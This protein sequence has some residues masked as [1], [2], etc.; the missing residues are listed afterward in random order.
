MIFLQTKF[1][2]PRFTSQRIA[3]PQLAARIREHL[4][5]RVVMLIAPPGYGKTT[6]MADAVETPACPV[7]WYQLDETDNDPT[8][9]MAYLLHGICQTLP[10]QRAII[11]PLIADAGVHPPQRNLV[12][13]LNTLTEHVSTEWTLVLDDYHLVSH[14][15][16][17]QL[18]TLLIDNA[19]PT[20]GV[21]LAARSDPP[22]PLSRWRVRGQLHELRAEHL[23]FSLDEASVWLAR[24][25]PTLK[26][27]DIEHLVATTEGWGAGL[28]LAANLLSSPTAA[29][30]LTEKLDG[31][32]Q[33]IFNYLMEEVFAHQ[34]VALQHFLLDSA[35]FPQ[36]SADLCRQVLHLDNAE[37]LLTLVQRANLFLFSLDHQRHWYRYHP[38]FREF[39]LDRLARQSAA[40]LTELQHHAAQYYESRAE[41][42]SALQYYLL[43]GDQARAAEMLKR[44][45][46]DYL[47]H[48]RV[49]V[50]CRYFAQLTYR[51]SP[52]MLLLHG[53][54]LRQLG[55]LHDAVDQLQAA[56]EAAQIDQMDEVTCAAL[57]EI[58]SIAR[59]QGDYR[60][61]QH[62]ALQAVDHSRRTMAAARAFALIEL[63][64]SQG[65]LEGMDLGQR[66][67]EQAVMEMESA[68]SSISAY[69]Q[70]QFLR[71]L[72]QICWW[73]GDVRAAIAH[74]E[75]ALRRVPNLQSPLAAEILITLAT[76]YLYRHEYQLALSY[77]ERALTI[78]QQ[79]QIRELLPAVYTVLGNIQTRQGALTQAEQY[80]R[81]AIEL[82]TEL[83]AA[84]HTQVMAAG[85]LAH[86]LAKQGL[87]ED[88]LQTAEMALWRH[89][90]QPVVYEV[91][92]CRS[93][94]ADNYLNDGQILKAKGIFEALIELGEK[95]QYRIPLAMAYFGLAYI[96]LR[97][98]QRSEG[99]QHGL[100]SLEL[101]EPSKAWEL[102]VD[103]GERAI[104][105]CQALAEVVPD[106][107]FLRQTL[108]TLQR[109]APTIQIIA[110]AEPLRVQT[111]GALRVF[112][113]DK[114]L[115]PKVW[116]SSKAKELL[117]YFITYR[118]RYIALERALDAVW[119]DD[120]APGKTAFHTALYRLR[121]ALNEKGEKSKYILLEGGEYQLDALAFN[122]DVDQFEALIRQARQASIE[123]QEMLL[124]RAIALYH[125]PY[126][127][128]W[129][130]RWVY[131]ERE[132]L[133]NIFLQAL[134]TLGKIKAEQGNTKA[135]LD[136]AW[137][138]LKVDPLLESAHRDIM[139]YLHQLGDRQG[140]TRQYRALENALSLELNTS[141]MLVTQQLFQQLSQ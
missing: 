130:C 104:Q 107:F 111:F 40:S 44:F 96:L 118:H 115:S 56:C 11:E 72:G 126:L 68:G 90:G 20:M 133:Q 39:L 33:Y 135:A 119:P 62:F 41:Y 21:L 141:P 121:N 123:Q 24:E 52:E 50:L 140:I 114:E 29:S 8:T 87:V 28:Q 38:L 23:R 37:E 109:V 103:Q 17:H 55:R 53:R 18:T 77:A 4:H 131:G 73:R 35:V 76:P 97:A 112:R 16:V 71:S 14:P 129:S 120:E 48:G 117:A 132:R 128:D 13:L 26:Q 85:Y 65:F 81:Q 93:V 79:F 136:L 43:A 63:A 138:Q 54:A 100:R 61:A 5:R 113:A 46:V 47:Q 45:A 25:Q 59:S 19:P 116:V 67:A 82:A 124:Q 91:Y 34:P 134:Q 9:F 22:L 89:E 60:R 27:T 92:V 127:D 70:A 6:A 2:V 42:E 110:N 86:N 51:V 31:A 78:C 94:L 108:H 1:L 12:L 83:G 66:L 99:M 122:L 137:E 7:L 10:E 75:D 102:Y 69:D 64:K 84:S 98:G 95:R 80:L 30:A 101:L 57:C 36:I 3:R 58:A 88:A 105:V 125:G 49:D 74:C 32:H 139:R 106:N 15:A